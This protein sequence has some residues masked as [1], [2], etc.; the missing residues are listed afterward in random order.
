VLDSLIL[1][2][3]RTDAVSMNRMPTF[4]IFKASKEVSR[5]KGADAKQLSE[6]IKKLAAEA[7]STS[8]S[9]SG[10]FDSGS[11]HW[12]GA[13]IPKGYTDV[14]D[15]VDVRGL[16]LLN[17]DPG[18]G[19]ARALFEASK[20]EG[21]EKDWVESDTDEQL[22]LY[23]PFQSTV[24]IHSLHITSHAASAAEDDT[25]E[26]ARPSKLRLYTNRISNLG[27]DEAGDVQATQEI[28]IKE[29]QWDAKTKTAKVDLR[30][31]KFQNIS[32]MVVFVEAVEG[33]GEKCRIDRLR[34]VGEKGEKRDG[35]I[36]K[37][38]HEH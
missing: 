30:F 2:N 35:K 36:E 18:Q 9:S 19:N 32:S 33:T 6:A 37:I 3:H 14:T 15:Q 38:D 20:P 22:M 1:N 25:A 34:V 13:D 29:T 16:D 27:F 21:K 31:V 10:G 28:E 12:L 11:S 17:A 5:I 23:V 7:D 24:K 8:S 4:L 26:V